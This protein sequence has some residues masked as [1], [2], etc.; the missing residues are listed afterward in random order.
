MAASLFNPVNA[1]IR[2]RAFSL[3][4]DIG[5]L[6]RKN[7]LAVIVHHRLFSPVMVSVF[8]EPGAADVGYAWG[9]PNISNFTGATL[10]RAAGATTSTPQSLY[11]T[12]G[13]APVASYTGSSAIQ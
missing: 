7:L 9:Y 11:S 13:Y 6:V 1:P 12:S 3:S 5:M 8:G 2:H 4:F 10:E